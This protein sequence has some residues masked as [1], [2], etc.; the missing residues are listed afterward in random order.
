MFL[1]IIE[2][3]KT[4]LIIQNLNG[5]LQFYTDNNCDQIKDP[6]FFTETLFDTI[7]YVIFNN[8]NILKH[9]NTLKFEFFKVIENF[10]LF[11]IDLHLFEEI[12]LH[13]LFP[14]LDSVH[15]P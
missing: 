3:L 10:A 13:C 1:L 12:L 2:S 11:A 9:K 6:F 5:N 15:V 7:Y 8:R 4:I 14:L